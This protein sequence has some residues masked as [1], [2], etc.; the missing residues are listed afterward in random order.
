MKGV[1]RFGKK[2]K[3][4][5]RYIGPFDILKR[6][7]EVAYK[8]ALP[9]SLAAFHPVFHVS[10]LRIYHANLS[11]VLD[12]S[13]VQLDMDMSYVEES[14][15]ILDREVRKLRAKNIDLVKVQWMGK[16]VEEETLETEHDIRSR[17]PHLFTTSGMSLYSFEDERLF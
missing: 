10:M 8:L 17:Y 11:H 6:I 2:G 16:L 15:G 7:G 13:S 3:L 14:V 1:M 4:S 12:L 5:P 9:P